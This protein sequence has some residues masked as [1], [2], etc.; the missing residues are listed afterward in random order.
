LHDAAINGNILAVRALVVLGADVNSKCVQGRTALDYAILHQYLNTYMPQNETL[1]S[2]PSFHWDPT[3]LQWMQNNSHD[4]YVF[5]FQRHLKHSPTTKLRDHESVVTYLEND[6]R[7][8]GMP[9][10]QILQEVT[11]VLEAAGGQQEEDVLELQTLIGNLRD[12]GERDEHQDT[13]KKIQEEDLQEEQELMELRIQACA[14]LE[15]MLADGEITI[16]F[17]IEEVTG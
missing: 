4:P 5:S 17:P 3:V 15:A 7:S 11:E 13:L 1:D 12:S 16:D 9:R 10:F 2:G 14:S 6:A 8:K